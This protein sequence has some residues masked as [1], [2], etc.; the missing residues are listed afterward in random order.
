MVWLPLLT[1]L[2]L[3]HGA[4]DEGC[5][6]LKLAVDPKTHTRRAENSA[7]RIIPRVH[8]RAAACLAGGGLSGGLGQRG[9]A[10]LELAVLLPARLSEMRRGLPPR[11][12]V[13]AGALGGEQLLDIRNVR[14]AL[15]T[16]LAFSADSM[17]TK[18]SLTSGA[19][20]KAAPAF[21]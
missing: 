21:G 20:V 7:R 8:V 4:F 13:G 2:E 5:E 12:R 19:W 9:V 6:R 11:A 16:S 3:I 17:S 15:A 14:G 1:G 10:A 18:S